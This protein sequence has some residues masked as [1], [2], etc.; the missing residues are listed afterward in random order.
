[1]KKAQ[2][3]A[4][5]LYKDIHIVGH[6]VA[7]VQTCLLWPEARWCFDVAQGPLYCLKAE[8]FFISHCHM[9]HA[10]GIPYIISQKALQGLKPPRFYMPKS[11]CEP[12]H[13]I[14]SIWQKI[15]G[16]Q[17]QFEFIG[18]GP[19]EKKLLKPGW[20]LKPFATDHRVDSQGYGLWREKKKLKTEYQ[21]L[22]SKALADLK[23]SGRQEIE[24][25]WWE[26]E[27]AYTGDTRIDV[28]NISPEIRKAKVLILEVTYI[29]EKKSIDHARTWGHVHWDEVKVRLSDL[30]C[31]K[32]L[33]IH[34]SARYSPRQLR[35]II[36]SQAP[37]DWQERIDVLST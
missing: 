26:L 14:M 35:E 9:D 24:E 6:S 18:L 3:L 16:H 20:V 23:R 21:Q 10:A 15:E 30:E 29:D 2:Q 5:W 12:L 28:L 11:M 1:M 37:A 19:G 7:G 36:K 32:L 17:Y 31:E 4:S 8:D 33:L 34:L 25:R 27:L 22:N 13:E